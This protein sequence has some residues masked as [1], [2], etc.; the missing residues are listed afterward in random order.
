MKLF[1]RSGCSV[2]TVVAG[3]LL[4]VSSPVRSETLSGTYVGSGNNLAIIVELVD[5]GSTQIA[6]RY[7]HITL[8]S[9]GKL[10]RINA[11][12]KGTSDGSG[13]VLEIKPVEMLSGSFVVSGKLA[14]LQA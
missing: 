2:T 4:L 7:E 11:T 9:D 5:A 3:L 6:G 10:E 8:T 1:R 14:R 13:V 12:V